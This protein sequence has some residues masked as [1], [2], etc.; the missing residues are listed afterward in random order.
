MLKPSVARSLLGSMRLVIG[1]GGLLAPRFGARVFGLQP[2]RNPGL[3]YTMRLFAVRDAAMGAG[4]I[5]AD[6]RDRHRWLDLGIASDVSDV[7]AALL[8]GRSGA[9][10][11]RAAA[12]CA[13]A[14]AVAVGLGVAA[15]GPES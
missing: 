3:P 1:V 6:P 12:M 10:P 5:A 14:A 13:F 9:L 11:K 15:R 2:E 4:L 8:A 7:G